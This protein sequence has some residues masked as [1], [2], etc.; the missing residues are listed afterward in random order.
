LFHAT[1]GTHADDVW[2]A[3]GTGGQSDI[4]LYFF[5]ALNCPRCVDAHPRVEALARERPWLRR[6]EQELSRR[7]ITSA[8]TRRWPGNSASRPA[9]YRP[10]R[11]ARHY[12]EKAWL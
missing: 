1:A 9:R 2:I 6:H 10:T 3:A 8:G 5:W 11:G 4:Q 12:R 7:P